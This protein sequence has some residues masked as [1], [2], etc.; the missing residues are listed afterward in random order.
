MPDIHVNVENPEPPQE[1]NDTSSLES[2]ISALEGK[3]E[4]PSYDD[5][6]VTSRIDDLEGQMSRLVDA[7]LKK[8]SSA[9]ASTET[10]AGTQEQEAPP[11]PN[12]PVVRNTTEAEIRERPPRQ[13]HFLNRRWF[14]RG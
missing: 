2:R 12:T 3:P 7:L 4:P 1:P 13:Q 6:G 5:S 11:L 8:E 9:N 14:S 10:T